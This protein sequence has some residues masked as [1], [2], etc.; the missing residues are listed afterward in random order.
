MKTTTIIA[1]LLA[2][3]S[4]GRARPRLLVSGLAATR[5]PGTADGAAIP[6]ELRPARELA[7][8][9]ADVPIRTSDALVPAADVIPAAAVDALITE[10][11]VAAEARG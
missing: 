10:E 11:G 7:A 8:Y 4:P 9:L 6:V 2:A 3:V 1:G 5:D